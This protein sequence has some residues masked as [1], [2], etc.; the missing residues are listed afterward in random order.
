MLHLV[1]YFVIA[2]FQKIH[3]Y[4][5]L[6]NLC[7]LYCWKRRF[8]FWYHIEEWCLAINKVQSRQ[9]WVHQFL[10]L[11][12]RQPFK[13]W[14]TSRQCMIIYTKLGTCICREHVR[15]IPVIIH[16]ITRVRLQQQ[17]RICG[18]VSELL[19]L[20]IHPQRPRIYSTTIILTTQ[21]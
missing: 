21:L 19:T 8:S 11:P 5:V 1:I 13:T 14:S 10:P 4:S 12:T 18:L 9:Q 16:S 15:L 6:Q 3:H 17:T 7:N 20:T 2:T